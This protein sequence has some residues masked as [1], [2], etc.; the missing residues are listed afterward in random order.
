M[1]HR[2]SFRRI[3][4]LIPLLL[5]VA[6]GCQEDVGAP[7]SFISEGPS[8]D[9]TGA[10]REVVGV[11]DTS[12]HTA[13]EAMWTNTDGVLMQIFKQTIDCQAGGVF[14]VRPTGWP[15]GYDVVLTVDPGTVPLN[16]DN[17]VEFV[18]E[19]PITGPS[20]GV[21]SVPY[22]F[23]PDGIIFNQPVHIT[24]AWPE[25]AGTA[26]ASGMDLWYIEQE[27]V[28]TAA[29]YQVIDRKVSE[30]VAATI[31]SEKVALAPVGHYS[32][33]H[34]S[35]WNVVDDSGSSDDPDDPDGGLADNGTVHASLAN[36]VE[37]D[38]CWQATVTDPNRH[39]A[40]DF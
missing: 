37:G 1:V 11:E 26:P 2:S 7:V 39:I 36:A 12:L 22:E 27:F 35:R 18:M 33:D 40:I 32:I 6:S 14:A 13:L 10:L 8:G 3:L 17:M 4:C 16:H 28:D 29:H 31:I 25:W 30:P 5:L 20:S 34:F 9:D 19:I 38:C 21:T 23:H 24:V 15:E